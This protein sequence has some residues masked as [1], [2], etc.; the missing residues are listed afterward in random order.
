MI[1][2]KCLIGQSPCGAVQGEDICRKCG[3]DKRVRYVNEDAALLAKTQAQAHYWQSQ[4]QNLQKLLQTAK[5]SAS[6]VHDATLPNEKPHATQLAF[7]AVELRAI[8]CFA[9]R[10]G[11]PLEAISREKSFTSDLGADSLDV[12]ELVMA[13]EDEFC[14]EIPDEDVTPMTTVQHALDYLLGRIKLTR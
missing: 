12:V 2:T 11:I 13:I 6:E 14:I 10:L 3:L 7:S 4:A 1:D 8:K 5:S 9:E